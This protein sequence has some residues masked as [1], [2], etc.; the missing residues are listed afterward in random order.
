MSAR[1]HNL[2]ELQEYRKQCKERV[3]GQ[4][5]RVSVC[6]GTGCL[7]NGSADVAEAVLENARQQGLT[8]GKDFVTFSTGCHGFCERG[9]IV[10]VEPGGFFYVGVKPGDVEE[11][12]ERTLLKG[13][14]VE[15]LQ[16][17][18]PVTGSSCAA[19]GEIP[20]Y[21]LQDRKVLARCGLIAPTDLDAVIAWDGYAGLEKALGM[22]PDQILKEIDVSMLRG[23]GG[24]GFPTGRKWISCAKAPGSPKY[25]IAN[26]DEGDP[27][28]FMDRSL[29]E[30]DPHA[31]LEGMII[32]A[33]AIGAERGFIY[34]RNEYPLAIRHLE[35]AIVQAKEAGLLGD[36]ILGSGFSFSVEICRGGGAFVCGESSALMASIEGR[37][38]YPRVKY[39][40]ATDKGL[41]DKPTVLN[42]VE[43]WAN[44]PIILREGAEGFRKTGTENSPGTKIFALVGKVRNTGLAEVPMG[45]TL[46]RIIEEIGGGVAGGRKAKAVQTGG[47][48]GGCLPE[49]LFDLT[50]DFDSLTEA[51]SMMG[52]GGMIVM[53]EQ[54]CMVDVAKY[55]INFLSEES[56]GKCTPCREG[57]TVLKGLLDDL[58]S[59]KGREG[60]LDLLEKTAK[61]MKETALCGLGQTAANPVLSTL[62]YF[63]NE[64]EEH[65]NGFCRA[66]V[67]KGMFQ[68]GVDPDSCIG[69]GLCMKECPAGA[70]RMEK[71]GTVKKAVI[72]G[73]ACVGCG[74]C[75]R[76]CP[77]GAISAVRKELIR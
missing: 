34:V 67:C 50:V 53:D 54:T 21:A 26:G 57:L 7:A 56:C 25:V 76:V 38:G 59:S 24:G 40:H 48:S 3:G 5:P 29:M 77:K 75:L 28:A 72:D 35:E 27:G 11:I 43:T 10:H 9:P 74:A 65:L 18:D 49:E 63:R 17:K 71:Q 12:I 41:W 62:R 32:G 6:G 68:A 20:F 42:N 66:G 4:T 33:Y 69:C 58:T 51:G 31:V 39:T 16:Y 2:L 61:G 47:P 36:D 19:A 52:S 8:P 13:E 55:F 60:D 46:R 45:M 44:V 14:T 70:I 64:Y 30:G 73:M 23:R 1:F 37:P 22:A 15:R